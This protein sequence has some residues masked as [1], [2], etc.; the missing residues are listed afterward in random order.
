MIVFDFSEFIKNEYSCNQALENDE[1]ELIGHCKR[2][3][4]EVNGAKQLHATFTPAGEDFD[5]T[6]H[7][8][9]WRKLPADAPLTKDYL[10]D[11]VS[12]IGA[13]L[14]LFTQGRRKVFDWRNNL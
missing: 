12:D 4:K 14:S 9:V 8:L 11:I 5:G 1:G 6:K 10:V 2:F 13:E 3:I 7:P